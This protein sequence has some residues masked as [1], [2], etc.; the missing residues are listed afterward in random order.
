[1]SVSTRTLSARKMSHWVGWGMSVL[2]I[3]L[4]LMDAT[5]KLMAL[6]PAT[7][8]GAELGFEGVEMTRT[9]GTILLICTVLY[10]V[11][12]TS[13]LGAILL[14]AYLGGAVATQLRVDAPLF[15]HILVGVYLGVLLWGGLWLRD[16]RVRA[17]MPVRSLDAVEPTSRRSGAES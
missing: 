11:P 7:E 4:L 8:T 6:R 10:V 1:M 14:T 5:T 3:A 17:L 16:A 13:V 2:V 12:W 15:T 9:L